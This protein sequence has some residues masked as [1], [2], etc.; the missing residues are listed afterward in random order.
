M[1]LCR[2]TTRRPITTSNFCSDEYFRIAWTGYLGWP[3]QAGRRD[4]LSAASAG[5]VSAGAVAAAAD[6]R[7]DL[8]RRGTL[9]G[10]HH[11]VRAV[12]RHGAGAAGLSAAG[13]LWLRVRARRRCRTGIDPRTRT[14]ADGAAV[15]GPRG[16]RAGLGDRAHGCHR[17]ADG[18]GAAGRGYG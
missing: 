1:V 4:A 18:H 15:R 14:G 17:P 11:V 13:A 7:A 6:N 10:H 9:P 3:D 2:S 5:A 12:R 16:H 8:Q